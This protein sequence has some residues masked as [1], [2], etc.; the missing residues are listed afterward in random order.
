MLTTLAAAAE[1]N[2]NSKKITILR[3][4]TMMEGA[5][6]KAAEFMSMSR[7]SIGSYFESKNAKGIGS[8]LSFDEKD[9]LMPRLIDVP[10]DDR[11]FLDTVRKFFESLQT[12]VPYEDGVILEIGL[13]IDNSKPIT[14]FDEKR[15][16]Y[17]TP[18]AYM[19]YVRYRHA[20]HH[21]KVAASYAEAQGNQLIDFYIFDP[22][23]A[24]QQ[25][26]ELSNTKDKALQI[27]LKIKEDMVK[28][29]A[30]I[31]LMGTDPRTFTGAGKDD[32]KTTFLRKQADERSVKFLE[33]YETKMFEEKY[34]LQSMMNT[35]IIRR[36]GNQYIDSETG[37]IIGNNTEEAMYFFKDPVN[38]DKISIL[39]ANLQEMLKIEI[40]TSKKSRLPITR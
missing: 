31:T 9:L 3:K 40:K 11:T 23:T 39:K 29:D 13:S 33:E 35:G 1:V 8:G 38:S 37:K 18:I 26:T 2:P 10:K 6:D 20:M 5:Q 22:A 19:D 36:V 28:V 16:K 34:M 21:P 17:N 7:K 25:D 14:Y 15:D 24:R 30:M 4:P 27:Y 32:E 12:Y